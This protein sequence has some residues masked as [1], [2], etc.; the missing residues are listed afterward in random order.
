MKSLRLIVLIISVLSVV[1]CSPFDDG[2]YRP[3]T[4]GDYDDGKYYRPLDEGKYVPGD[5]GRYTYIY[6]QGIWPYDGTYKIRNKE[7]DPY[8]GYRVY[9]SRY[10][11]IHGVIKGLVTKYVSSDN[12]NFGEATEGSTNHYSK[13]FADKEVAVKCKYIMPDSNGSEFT[14]Q[15]PPHMKVN[16]GE[17]LGTYYSYKGTKVLDTV[18]NS[19]TNKL[20][21]Q[22]EVFVKVVEDISGPT[23][24]APTPPAKEEI[25]SPLLILRPSAFDKVEATTSNEVKKSISE[26]VKTLIVD[27]V[28]PT[29]GGI[30]PSTA[31]DLKQKIGDVQLVAND[32]AKPTA[33]YVQSSFDDTVK[34]TTMNYNSAEIFAQEGIILTNNNAKVFTDDDA[35]VT[36]INEL[37]IM[38]AGNR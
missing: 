22:Y 33:P 2:K 6:Q 11:Y 19:L 15:Y 38:E 24:T 10:P 26:I 8:Q 31:E 29:V 9:A 5:E 21:L 4:Y 27:D 20:K 30:Q 25:K 14:T 18:S 37:L 23:E 35:S 12:I 3:K 34:T 1:L 17:K 32:E 13:V 28:L 36:D 16:D 7:D